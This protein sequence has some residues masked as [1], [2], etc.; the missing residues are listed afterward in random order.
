MAIF[1]HNEKFYYSSFFF[2]ITVSHVTLWQQA[3][4]GCKTEIWNLKESGRSV[5]DEPQPRAAC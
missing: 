4:N 3:L 1:F 5:I 2:Y